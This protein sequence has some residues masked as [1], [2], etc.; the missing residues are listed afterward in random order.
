MSHLKY[1][2]PI[3]MLV[4]ALLSH[5]WPLAA[6]VFA[7]GIDERTGGQL[8]NESGQPCQAGSVS[9]CL[10]QD[11]P[12]GPSANGLSMGQAARTYGLD[13]H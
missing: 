3:V 7:L 4:S 11:N 9:V 6:V 8:A 5:S 1:P 12:V 13:L 2:L 10:P